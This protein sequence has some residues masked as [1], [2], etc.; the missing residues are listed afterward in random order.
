MNWKKT[1]A[2][3]G[4]ITVGIVITCLC[5]VSAFLI[6][7]NFNRIARISQNLQYILGDLTFDLGNIPKESL[8]TSFDASRYLKVYDDDKILLV[9]FQDDEKQTTAVYFG[10]NIFSFVKDSKGDGQRTIYGKHPDKDMLGDETYYDLNIDGQFDLKYK[11]GSNEESKKRYIYFKN[12][13]MNVDKNDF[14]FAVKSAN[15]Y[16][17]DIQ[18][19]WMKLEK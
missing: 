7:T 2:R 13:W 12:Q 6:D 17:F 1:L 11:W 3:L 19:G 5:I 10:E 16:R 18:Q 15:R 8:P 9:I 14:N 4:W